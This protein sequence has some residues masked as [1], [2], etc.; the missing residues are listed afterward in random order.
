MVAGRD[1]KLFGEDAIELMHAHSGGVPRLINTIATGALLT[2]FG[3]GEAFVGA[4]IVEDVIKDLG[5]L[6]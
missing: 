5:F 4:G 2:G 1:E 3:A 6:D